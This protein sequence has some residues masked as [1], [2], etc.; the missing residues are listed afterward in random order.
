MH[1]RFFLISEQIRDLQLPSQMWMET[2]E[3]IY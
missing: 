3:L 2:K 1:F